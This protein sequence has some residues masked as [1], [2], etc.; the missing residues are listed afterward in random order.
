M[1]IPVVFVYLQIIQ[2]RTSE[3]HLSQGHVRVTA[4]QK[5]LDLSAD[6]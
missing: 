1:R 3:V 6:V 2:K 4:V 5:A